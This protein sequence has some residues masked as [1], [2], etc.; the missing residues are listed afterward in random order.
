M[1]GSRI[2]HVCLRTIAICMAQ[3]SFCTGDT[4]QYFTQR[5]LSLRNWFWKD[6]FATSFVQ[7]SKNVFHQG[8]QTWRI[9]CCSTT[10][11]NT[12][13]EQLSQ[14]WCTLVK[15]WNNTWHQ[16]ATP[17]SRILCHRLGWTQYVY[18]QVLMPN[19]ALDIVH[20]AKASKSPGNPQVLLNSYT[21]SDCVVAS[22]SMPAHLIAF[23]FNSVKENPLSNEK[24]SALVED[25]LSM[26]RDGN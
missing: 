15:K 16:P 5:P 17:A 3:V 23:S 14:S 11:P 6:H 19:K 8:K 25:S 13:K 1:R 10:V 24:V 12:G 7:G 9:T 21:A 18:S 26:A 4:S 2:F 22:L 20:E